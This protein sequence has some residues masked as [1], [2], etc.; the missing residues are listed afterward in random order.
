MK[1][2]DAVNTVL[3]HLGEHVITSI[4]TTKHPTVGLIVAAINRQT[5]ALLTEGYWFNERT[6]TLQVNTDGRI[7]APEKAIAIYGVDCT[8]SIEGEYLYDIEAGSYYFDRPITVKIIR[9]IPF[10]HL[11][12]YAALCIAYNAG[13]EQYTT[14]FGVESAVGSLQALA[15]WNRQ[16]LRQEERRNRKSNSTKFVKSR[17]GRFRAWR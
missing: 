16:M 7:N 10:E 6:I 9:D 3:P 1:L 12:E 11:P 4:E 13:A 2:L 17:M 8:V 5:R 15:E 14:D